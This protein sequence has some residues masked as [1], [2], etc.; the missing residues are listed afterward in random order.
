MTLTV[1][2][3]QQSPQRWLASCGHSVVK[4]ERPNRDYNIYMVRG[5]QFLSLKAAHMAACRLVR[6]MEAA[7]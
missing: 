6:E 7:R 4:I 3:I 5:E 2:V 1:T